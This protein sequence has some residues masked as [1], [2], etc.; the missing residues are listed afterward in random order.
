MTTPT[1][2]YG[3]L[4]PDADEAADINVLNTL[5]DAMDTDIKAVRDSLDSRIYSLGQYSVK[6]TFTYGGGTSPNTLV[7]SVADLWQEDWFSTGNVGAWSFAGTGLLQF[8]EAGIYK[9]CYQFTL[10]SYGS[11]TTNGTVSLGMHDYGSGDLL[12]RTKTYHR[13]NTCDNVTN[14]QRTTC[15]GAFYVWAGLGSDQCQLDT[16]YNFSFQNYSTAGVINMI[17]SPTD[18]LPFRPQLT[19]ECVRGGL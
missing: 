9:V 1:T 3:W 13:S 15:Q 6:R 12:P 17:S 11:G 2:N 7:S 5:F 8:T 19:I 14:F 4:K 16:E 18:L 10:P